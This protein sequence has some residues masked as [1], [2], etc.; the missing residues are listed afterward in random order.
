MKYKVYIISIF[1]LFVQQILSAQ[2]R[3][4]SIEEAVNLALEQSDEAKMANQ[5][6]ETAASQLKTTKNNQ[7]PDFKLS[8][9]YSYLSNADV[10]FKLNTGSSS[11]EGSEGQQ[12]G[13]SPKI[14]QLLLGQANVSMPIFSGFKLKNAIAADENRLK[15]ATF[16]AENSKEQI[17]L[18]VIQDYLS[19][20]KARKAV[21]LLEE[22]L[23]GAERR[24]TDF[25]A[26]EQNGL[27]AR[28]DLL[29]AQ[30]QQANTRL[31]LEEAR[32]NEQV[33]NFQ[34]IKELNLPEGTIVQTDDAS[35]LMTPVASAEETSRKD[36]EALKFQEQAAENG[37]EVAKSAYFPSIGLTGGYIA[38]DV[39]NALTVSNAM[40]FGVGL[41]YNLSSI[42]KSK[43][44]VKLAE[45][46][47]RELQFQID[48]VEDQVH[49]QVENAQKE[50]E[51]A[52]KK[53]DVYS[54]SE[55]QAVE[56]FRIVKD[57]YDNGL[58]DTNDL[59][60]ADVEQLQAKINMAYAKAN[61][62]QKY[63]E[64]LRAKGGLTQNFT[65]D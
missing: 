53:L 1:C 25:S 23:K 33:I 50:Y 20:Y 3:Q 46:R 6:V 57:K 18:Q 4:L 45:S 59:L 63:Y 64:L 61:I 5:T 38:L 37:V 7:Y 28:N 16:S 48:Q 42:F 9:Q 30:L 54:Q 11:S 24:V 58:E 12:S 32:K 22:S 13:S 21:E 41:S 34:L 17:A 10:N 60:E 14:N 40:N 65:K 47:A 39:H 44:D 51:L 62:A 26:M 55:E 35:F 2:E 8:G 52:L 31:N 27:L 15:A 36:L 43:Q 49:I 19:L 56:N 29:K